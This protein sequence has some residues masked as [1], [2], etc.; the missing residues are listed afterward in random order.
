[1]K[2][3][4][5][6][7]VFRVNRDRRNVSLINRTQPPEETSV[8]FG[9]VVPLTFVILARTKK[10][11][12]ALEGAPKLIQT[13]EFVRGVLAQRR[14]WSANFNGFYIQETSGAVQ[15]SSDSLSYYLLI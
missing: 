8:N 13:C 3:E 12:I 2:E 14:Y 6:C 9:F 5:N 7:A 15:T 11:R 1:M 10:K 4:R